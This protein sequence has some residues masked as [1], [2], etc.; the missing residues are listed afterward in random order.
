MAQII[1]A[2]QLGEMENGNRIL[3]EAPQLVNSKIAFHGKGNILICEQSVRIVNSTISFNGSNSIVY[4]SQSRH[5][6]YL[7]A[8]LYN[9]STLYIGKNSFLNGTLN[10]ILSEQKHCLIGNESLILWGI[11]IRTADPHLVYD[12]RTNQRINPSKS[13]F[14]GDHV[15]IGQSAMLLKGTQIDSGSIIGA[16]SLVAGKK[17]PYNESWGGNPCRKIADSIFWD[18]STVHTWTESETQLGQDF[19]SY[20]EKRNVSPDEYQ[21]AYDPNRSIPYDEISPM[22]R[23]TKSCRIRTWLSKQR[24]CAIF[25]PRRTKIG[26]H[27]KL[28]QRKNFSKVETTPSH[29]SEK[30]R[31]AAL[32]QIQRNGAAHFVFPRSTRRHPHGSNR[33]QF[34]SRRPNTARPCPSPVFTRAGL[35]I[36]NDPPLHAIGRKTASPTNRFTRQRRRAGK[37]HSAL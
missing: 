15:W 36:Y 12:S 35:V 11:W 1:T 31:R 14:I 5:H 28:S 18:G 10:I 27:T 23:S 25:H 8:S 22:M 20:A 17:V 13:V 32:W 37:S 3:G 7:S 30:E 2:G 16:A 33:A 29:S 24:I 6:Y 21:F 19:S 9:N 4:L 34:S 26:F